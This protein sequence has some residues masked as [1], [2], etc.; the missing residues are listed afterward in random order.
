MRSL[1]LAFLAGL[2]VLSL[3]ACA[4]RPPEQVAAA[5]LAFAAERPTPAAD[6]MAFPG[7]RRGLSG[8]T[9]RVGHE[10]DI[11]L[12]RGEVV[13][14]FDDGPYPGRTSAIL[15]TLDS[16]GVKGTFFM[17]GS[18]AAAH[19]GTAR[20][21]ATRGHTI[22]THTQDHRNLSSVSFEAAMADIDR[23]RHNVMAATGAPARFFR[24]PYLASTPALRQQLA[25]QGIVDVSPT[26]DSKDYFSSTADQV[27]GRAISALVRRGSGVV[28]FHDIHQRTVS[29]LPGFLDDLKA[30]GFSV[31]RLVPGPGGGAPLV[32]SAEPV[33][34]PQ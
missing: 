12:A 25:S 26:V 6:I 31:V 22:G 32:A 4:S 24:F 5:K 16:Y 15:D 11:V 18:M 23:G 19:P 17:V 27:R 9:I 34:M 8:R 13:L 7:P 3:S 1:R 33:A 30:R 2:S 10:S 28:L 21:V 14:T 20:E 29:M